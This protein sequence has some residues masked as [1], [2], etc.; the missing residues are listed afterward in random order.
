MISNIGK[1]NADFPQLASELSL[2]MSIWP[3]DKLGISNSPLMLNFNHYC[4]L[5][6]N[7]TEK[8]FTEKKNEIRKNWQTNEHVT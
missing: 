2:P 3:I 1:L 6:G 4:E 8:S 5:I 7:W